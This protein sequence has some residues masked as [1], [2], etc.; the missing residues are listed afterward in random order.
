MAYDIYFM[1]EGIKYEPE[2]GT[3][4]VSIQ[5]KNEILDQSIKNVSD[6]IKVL[7][8]KETGEGIQVEDVTQAVSLIDYSGADT[9]EFVTDSFSTFVV[10]GISNS[11]SVINV[12]MKFIDVNGV[13]DT[14]VSGTY[15]LNVTDPNNQR[16][17][18]ALN[19]VNGIVTAQIP[20]LYDQN[21][22]AG[23]GGSLYALTNTTYTAVLFKYPS[24][25]A[26]NFKWDNNNPTN[27]IGCVKYELGSEIIENYTITEFSDAVTVSSGVGALAITAVA[28]SGT[29]LSSAEIQNALSQVSPYAVFA[30]EFDLVAH[31]EGSIAVQKANISGNFGNTENNRNNSTNLAI[32]TITVNKIYHGTDQK[33]FKF[34]LFQNN[35]LIDTV[36]ITL[37]TLEGSNT[38]AATFASIDSTSA[39]TVYEL[40]DNNSKL[41]VGSQ[42]DGFTLTSMET[43]D[44]TLSSTINDTSYIETILSSTVNTALQPG[45]ADLKNYLVVGSGYT[46]SKISNKLYLYKDNKELLSTDS[47]YC[48]FSVAGEGSFPINFNETLDKMAAL[49]TKLATALSSDTVLVKNMTIAELNS[50]NS[51]ELTFDT[52]GKML[53][54]NIDATGATNISLSANAHLKVNGENCAGWSKQANN[55]VVN[56]YTK[57]GNTYYPYEG[58]ITN[59]GYVMG[60]LMAPR[61]RIQSL[62]QNYNGNIIAH[63]VCSAGGEIHGNTIGTV[64]TET[65]YTFTNSAENFIVLPMTGGTGTLRIYQL[66][67]VIILLGLILTV[68]YLIDRKNFIT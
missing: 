44:K 55:I 15:Y 38:A 11:K 32:R 2:L 61:A 62:G 26:D 9:I 53:L 13:I 48:D 46:I 4:N 45:T 24:V 12:T 56:I 29:M 68:A 36:T 37:P 10:T 52:N 14:N 19:V 7:H 40:G 28:K 5:Y 3:V 66:G 43:K 16:Y 47:A 51:N 27:I 60:I 20:G 57:N 17:N 67:V 23:N 18:V 21:G 59:A 49:S 1:A 25:C 65:V 8:L 35:T 54:L 33:T 64:T 31:M 22:N 42:Y 41:S 63:Y 39:Y 30:S 34:G 58:S 50:R 6:E